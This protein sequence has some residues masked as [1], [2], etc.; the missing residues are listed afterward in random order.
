[1]TQLLRL[2]TRA[3]P[4]ASSLADQRVPVRS[5]Q[6]FAQDNRMKKSSFSAAAAPLG[7]AL[8]TASMLLASVSCTSEPENGTD[9]DSNASQSGDD[10]ASTWCAVKAVLDKNCI[11]C[12]DGE[13]TAG[14]PMPLLKYE[15]LQA[16]A[17]LSHGKK[18]FQAIATRIHDPKTPMPPK[19]PLSDDQLKLLDD[20]I[21]AKAPAGDDPTCEQTANANPTLQEPSDV[22]PPAGGCDE[23]YPITAHGD[24]ADDPYMVDPGVEMH[25]QISVDAPWGDEDVQAIA[26]HPITDNKK[27]IHHW[28]L[29]ANQGVAAFLTGW[30]PGDDKRSPMPDDVGM[31]MP[32]GKGALRLDIHYNS[33]T[34]SDREPD[35]SGV[36]ICIV[37]G[38]NIRKKHAA[39][40][41]SFVAFQFPLAPANTTNHEATGVCNV[42]A[43]EP[44]HLM[45]AGPHSHTYAV[46]HRFT[47][48]KKNG[49]EIVM[50]D[51]PFQFGEQKSYDLVPEVILETGDTVT[52]TCRYTN[53]TN[54][55]I[56]FGENTGDEMCFNFA[57]YYPKDAL[58]C[59]G[60]GGLIGGLL[61]SGGL[62]GGGAGGGGLL[63]G[64]I[65]GGATGGGATGGGATGGGGLL[66]GLF[67]P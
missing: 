52:T 49:D 18:V 41:M 35:R 48:T 6:S 46:G 53:T 21:A 1:M 59:G 56:N 66:G 28:I 65:G 4:L 25:P 67:G 32:K 37:K 42:T 51:R 61:N 11:E 9:T 19:G 5:A 3:E 30:A 50:L 29:Y 24:A 31:D 44:V 27:V 40:T 45:S 20:W 15:D 63:G 57:S 54:K 62:I 58:S 64:L 33:L 16:K 23:I 39:V 7:R 13:G 8:L 34:A 60:S 22:W 14:A 55:S 38:E 2:V 12:H 10:G 26:F 17:P 36:E 47:V 43:T